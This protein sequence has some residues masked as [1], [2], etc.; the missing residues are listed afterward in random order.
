[1]RLR[2]TVVVEHTLATCSIPSPTFR[3]WAR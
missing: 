2:G 1:M 3:R